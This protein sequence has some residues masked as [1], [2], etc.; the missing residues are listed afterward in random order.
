MIQSL[1]TAASGMRGYQT[2]LDVV[3]SNIA[4]AETYGYKK[5]TVSF[6]DALYAEVLDAS[7]GASTENLLKG[8]GVIVNSIAKVNTQGPMIS[9][10]NPLDAAITNTE[11][12]YTVERADGSRAYTKD[13]SF[14]L[15][16]EGDVG[17]I[18]TGNGE[19]VLDNNGNR[20]AIDFEVSNLSIDKNGNLYNPDNEIFATLGTVRFTNAAGLD[21]IGSNLFVETDISGA[22]EAVENPGITQKYLEGSNVDMGDEVVNMIKA[23]RA[24]QMSSRVLSIAD[25]MEEMANNLRR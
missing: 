21:A 25:Q 5:D 17:Y 4:N 11:A 13:G 22:A 15:S 8:S 1:H 9:T 24:Y 12:Y 14:T 10:L 3:A 7:N 23:Q 2:Q 19:Y 16:A 6:K 18:V 20:I